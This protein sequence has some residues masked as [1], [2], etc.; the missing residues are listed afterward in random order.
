MENKIEQITN[1]ADYVE[2]KLLC[3]LFNEIYHY[4][5]DDLEDEFDIL[6]MKYFKPRIEIA[7]KQFIIDIKEKNSQNEKNKKLN[8]IAVKL[9]QWC[10]ERHLSVE[11]QQK[12]LAGNVLEELSE[13][14]R[15]SNNNEK[16]DALCDICVFAINAYDKELNFYKQF[17]IYNSCLEIHS[18][19]ESIIT[20][21]RYN[22]IPTIISMCFYNIERLGYD[23]YEC[24]DETIKEISSRVGHYD[25]KIG[26]FV[27]DESKEAKSKWYK[28]NYLKCKIKKQKLSK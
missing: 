17:P 6:A 7:K 26:K 4:F 21:L 28:A 22:S 12:N 2:N 8:I 15:A 13:L 25:D 16:I 5:K 27:K 9:K 20:H 23:P 19:T 14:A 18:F 11:S 24:M 3:E 1:M 10:D